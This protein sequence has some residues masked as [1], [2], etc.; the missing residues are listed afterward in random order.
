MAVVYEIAKICKVS[1]THRSI[2]S[3]FASRDPL[4]NGLCFLIVLRIHLLYDRDTL[5]YFSDGATTISYHSCRWFMSA[6]SRA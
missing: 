5:A 1:Y 4:L 2:L 6:H 3:C